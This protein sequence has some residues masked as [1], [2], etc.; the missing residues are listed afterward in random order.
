MLSTKNDFIQQDFK[1]MIETNYNRIVEK[2]QEINPVSYSRNRNF[3]DGSI[4]KLSPYIARGVISTKM[5]MKS[6]IERDFTISQSYKFLQQLAWRDYFQR[7]AQHHKN[8]STEN[9]KN[10]PIHMVNLGLNNS[11]INANTGIDALDDGITD[12][13]ES[14]WIHNHMRMYLAMLHGNIF[15][16]DWKRGARWMYYYLLDADWASNDLSWQWVVGAN[17]NKL[18]FANQDNINKYTGSK[19][20][21]TY[22]DCEYSDLIFQQL[23]ANT[24]IYSEFEFIPEIELRENFKS[25]YPKILETKE[26]EFQ[27]EKS[28][29]VYTPYNLDP[30]W[31]SKED[32]TRV[33]YI[34]TNELIQRPM[35]ERT[36]DFI[37]SLAANIELDYIIWGDLS[38]I[39]NIQNVKIIIKE[40]P[41]FNFENAIVDSRDWM[42]PNIDKYYSSFFKYWKMAEKELKR[43]NNAEN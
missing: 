37:F 13:L 7:V 10:N 43:L 12:L 35:C 27:T 26:F 16:S 18:Y 19:Q 17:S 40:H 2:I 11:I 39:K 36:L 29:A 38:E 20:H 41:L 21:S 8:L 31:R 4:T 22:L 5:V 14:G 33:L 9:I 32:L 3:L 25:K 1:T 24:S 15:N 42:F 28:V 30:V 23:P 34:S 6:V